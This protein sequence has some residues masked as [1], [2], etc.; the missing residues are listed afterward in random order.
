LG[1]TIHQISKVI[2]IDK[3][4]ALAAAIKEVFPESRQF[5]CIWHINKCILVKLHKVYPDKT[6]QVGQEQFWVDWKQVYFAKTKREVDLKWKT[7]L[8]PEGQIKLKKYLESKWMSVK[9]QFCYAWTDDCLHFGHQST[10]RVESAH[11]ALKVYIKVSTGDLKYV[12]EACERLM[13]KQIKEHLYTF[14]KSRLRYVQAH[15]IVLFEWVVD[16][17]NPKALDMVFVTNLAKASSVMCY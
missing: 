14:E 2:F 6:H 15:S 11:Y 16:Y 3:E 1:L 7:L 10:S 13:K 12:V 5:Y 9:D 4:D 8:K 17:V